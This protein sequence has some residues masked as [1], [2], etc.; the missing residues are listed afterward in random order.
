MARVLREQRAAE[1]D[2]VLAGGGASSSMKVSVENAVCVEPTERH[3]STG[4]PILVVC[5]STARFGIA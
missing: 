4:T 3:H 1:V 5:R 2:R